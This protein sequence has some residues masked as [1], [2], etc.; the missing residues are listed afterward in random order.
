MDVVV[1]FRGGA[2]ALAD[3]RLRL[4]HL[5]LRPGDSLVLVDNTPGRRPSH[6][7]DGGGAPVMHAA[8]LATPGYARNRGAAS[9]SSDWLVFFDADVAAPADLLDRYFERPPREATGLLAGGVIDEA[10]PHAGPAAARYAYLRGLMSQEDTLRFG[11][12]GYPKTANLACRRR[13]FEGVGGFREHIRAGEDADL[14]FRMRA[15]GWE[16]ERRECAAVVH[17]SRRTAR[18]FT[19]QKL[20]HGSG[21]AWL[22]REYPGAFP[23]RRRPGL[24]WWGIR[25]AVGGTVSAARSQDRDRLLRA[26]FEPL[27]LIAHELGRS[28]PNE[29]PLSLRSVLGHL[30]YLRERP[31]AVR[32][33]GPGPPHP[34][35]ACGSRPRSRGPAR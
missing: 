28:L 19:V 27:E 25:H 17:R 13:A 32:M 29:R 22:D 6:D 11:E 18:E 5:R 15:A 7:R 23:A 31:D 33:R 21:A 34:G 26:L 3:L 14:S 12:W 10:V 16:V 4:G 24:L 1:P 9:G 2:T 35:V 20:C 8:H 30:R